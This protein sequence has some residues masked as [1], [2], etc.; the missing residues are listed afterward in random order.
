MELEKIICEIS[1]VQRA[2]CACFL[3]YVEY[4]SNT[5]TTMLLK[6]GHAKGRSCTREGGYNK[7]V[8]KVK[9]FLYSLYKNEYSI[10]TH[11]I[12]RLR[13]GLKYKEES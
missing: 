6:T 8:M 4:R 12:T 5:N 9:R 13:R 3:S 1:H 2:K 7:E 10:F 11:V